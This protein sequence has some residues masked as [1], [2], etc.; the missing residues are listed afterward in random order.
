MTRTIADLGSHVASRYSYQSKFANVNGWRMHYIDEGPPTA[1]PVLLLHG[2]P[3][4]GY[5]WR[6]TMP[7]LLAAGYRAR[8]DQTRPDQTRPNRLWL[9]RASAQR[10][11]SQP[12]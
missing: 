12:G 10:Q 2:N 9:V 7:P 1:P 11:R 3:T 6:D 8:P 4:W 5:L